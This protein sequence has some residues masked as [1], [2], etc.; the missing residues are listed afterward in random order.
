MKNNKTAKPKE[1]CS[2]EHTKPLH[3]HAGRSSLPQRSAMPYGRSLQDSQPVLRIPMPAVDVL[4]HFARGGFVQAP[5]AEQ[6][7]RDPNALSST[8]V[9]PQMSDEKLL[10][11]TPAPSP[12]PKHQ[13]FWLAGSARALPTAWIHQPGKPLLELP[14][15]ASSLAVPGSFPVDTVRFSFCPQDRRLSC[16]HCRYYP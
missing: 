5:S 1:L 12:F 7:K 13:R 11:P 16:S 2:T 14:L 9:I 15:S 4:L 8:R 10:P 3:S 6:H